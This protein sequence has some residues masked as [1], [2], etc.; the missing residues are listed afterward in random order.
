MRPR[1]QTFNLWPDQAPGARGKSPVDQPTLTYYPPQRAGRSRAAMV[2]LPGGSYHYLADHEGAGYARWLAGKG[3]H[4][5]VLN[6]RLGSRGYRHPVMLTDAARAVRFLRHHAARWRIAP[7]KIGIIGS[8]AGGHLAALLATAR[9]NESLPTDDAIDRESPR[10]DCVVLCYPVITLGPL[11]HAAS[12]S[13]LLGAKPTQALRRGVSAELRV[14]ARTPPCFLWHTVADGAVPVEHSLLF[15][16]A[17]RRRAIPFELHLYQ[18]GGH[19]LGL[20]RS[21][22]WGRACLRWLAR[23]FSRRKTSPET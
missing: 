9:K 17:L 5:F 16:R 7:G 2:V 4:A 23:H 14:T 11:T 20:G 13:N 15:A 1:P 8:S 3:Y 18:D 10:P 19:G 22:P 12:R 21:H 6:Y